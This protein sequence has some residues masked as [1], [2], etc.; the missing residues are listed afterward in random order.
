AVR[1]ADCVRHLES[2]GVTRYVELGPD[3]VLTAMA[4]A[5]LRD[6][7]EAVTVPALRKDRAEGPALLAAVARLHVTGA[8]VD[9]RGVFAGRG[10]RRVELPTYAFQRRRHWL[11]TQTV[12]G[13]ASGLGQVAARHP[14][15][16]AVVVSPDSDGLVLTGRLSTAA[17]PWLAGH[18]LLGTVVFPASGFVELAI[19]AGDQAGCD[20]LADLT[21]DGMLTLPAN[22]GV[23]VQVVVAEPGESGERSVTIHSRREDGPWTRN[24][25]GVLATGAPAPDFDLAAWPPAGADAMD[26]DDLYDRL[27]DQGHDY[28]PAF[29][30]LRAAWRRGDELF[31]EVALTEETDD[32]FGV[33]PAL[34][35]AATHLRTF[36]DEEGQDG[37]R[38]GPRLP[39]AWNRVVLHAAGATSL[40][41]RLARTE[42]DGMSLLAAD[43]A[44]RPVLS[45]RSLTSSPVSP[46]QLDAG[47]GPEG[48]LD[49]LFR[50]D[51]N[52]VDA[53]PATGA[54]EVSWL[55][56]EDIGDVDD[57][58]GGAPGILVVSPE[59]G[60]DAE[61]VHSSTRR[62]LGVL[63]DWMADE[64]LFASRLLV[65]TRGAVSLHGEDVTDLAGAAVWGLIRAA[66]LEHPGA[67][68]LADVDEPVDSAALA[69]L[70]PAVVATDEPELAVRAGVTYRAR[71]AR[72][73]VSEQREPARPASVFGP[74]EGTLVDHEGTLGPHEGTLAGHEGTVFGHEGTVLITGAMGMMGRHVARHLVTAHG[75]GHL[76]LAG[77][78][79][80][81]GAGSSELH[82]ELTALGATVTI[83]ACDVSDKDS[84]ARMLDGIDTAY[85]LVGVVH[86]A[87]V[88]DDG[89]IESLTPERIDAVMRPKVDAAFHLHELTRHLDLSAFVLFS[90]DSGVFGNGGQANYAAANTF[91]DG[92]AAH[93][94][95]AGLAAQSLAWSLWADASEMTAQ[96]SE[97]DRSRM[98]RIGIVGMSAA[99]GLELFDTAATVDEPILVPIKLNEYAARANPDELP[100]KLHGL[101][102][103]AARRT[104]R[105]RSDGGEALARKLAALAASERDELL[106]DLVR[107]RVA[108]VLRRDSASDVEPDRAFRELGFDSLTALELRNTLN[109]ATGLRLPATLLFDHPTARAVA[110]RIGST[111]GPKEDDPARP[112]LTEIERL[113]AALTS[114]ALTSSE[115][116]GARS[117]VTA[118]LEALLRSWRDGHD[119]PAEAETN[120]D[121]EWA[122]DNELFE[123]LDNELGIS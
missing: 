100:R 23:D 44:G 45:A 99:V 56:W 48:F 42:Q 28:G 108:T 36:H 107:E 72:V 112:V 50:M 64:R 119:R 43:E 110:R 66:Q 10:A 52:P 80:M 83:A 3:G 25:T 35:D 87:G 89:V 71:L 4:Q 96:L 94:R 6:P 24:A 11:D 69:A 67:I 17:Q 34:L 37:D 57:L 74:H 12:S 118:R 115:A 109:A 101:F 58:A 111:A 7:D 92:L 18:Q 65:V 123:A 84:V 88:L 21:I 55:P 76:L 102:G 1:F 27:A 77:R 90:S 113:E 86:A 49:S 51:W 78:R 19:R 120:S 93:R 63:Q 13:D 117:R 38:G 33:H 60:D 9:W 73:P 97:V 122:T 26:V 8:F 95:A 82:D 121:P 114:S 75:V 91:L 40:R 59:P 30:G 2:E 81:E 68:V 31:A 16:G 106:L 46:A 70:V 62:T 15:L 79:G 5:C 39:T 20:V 98:D 53:A 105:A 85:P 116:D 41:V 32:N 29:R 14:L 54:D 47:P 61:S 22:G 104:V 103:G